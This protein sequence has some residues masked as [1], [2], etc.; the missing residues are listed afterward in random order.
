MYT[1]LKSQCPSTLPEYSLTFENANTWR[2]VLRMYA[3]LTSV[4]NVRHAQK[5]VS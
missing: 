3:M 2:L 4:E 5:Y 1:I